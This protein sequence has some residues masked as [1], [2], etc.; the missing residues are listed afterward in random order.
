MALIYPFFSSV[1]AGD[2]RETSFPLTFERGDPQ[3][4]LPGSCG[5][6]VEITAPRPRPCLWGGGRHLLSRFP[7]GHW[8]RRTR[9]PAQVEVRGLGSIPGSGRPPED[10]MAA[11]SSILAW[12]IPR[13]EEP[14]GLQS[15]ASQ[16]V[17]HDQ[18]DLA[19]THRFCTY[20]C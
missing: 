17:R 8:G 6:G 20:C 7:G 11:H 4:R 3:D 9:L 18:S 2:C 10:D 1:R 13:T 14:G 12:R 16:T 15:L 19:G 5:T